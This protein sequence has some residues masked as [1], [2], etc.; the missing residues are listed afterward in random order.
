[1]T[2]KFGES[3]NPSGRP[4]NT[5]YRQQLF[6]TLVEPH[7]EALFETAINLALGG[8][9]TMLRLFLERMLPAKPADDTLALTLP[10]DNIIKTNILLSY[11]ENLLK[12]VAQCEIT[13]QQAKIVMGALEVQRKH[14][15]TCELKDRL[16]AIEQVLKSRE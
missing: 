11:G 1:M 6:N 8:N 7:K 5:G 2:F 12:A 4:K 3:G 10:D 14:I 16:H 13:P 9:E 15:E